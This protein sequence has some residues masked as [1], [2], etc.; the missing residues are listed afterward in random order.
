MALTHIDCNIFRGPGA[1]SDGSSYVVMN[2]RRM[3]G[4][5][6]VAV[7]IA[8]KESISS[9]V[10]CKL[11]LE[12]FTAGVLD[13]YDSQSEEGRFDRRGDSAGRQSISLE[14]LEAAFK[15]ANTSVYQFAHK[16]AA[17]GRMASTLMGVVLEDKVIAAGK[18]GPGNVFLFRNRELMAFF[19]PNQ[20]LPNEIAHETYIGAHS[21]VSVELASIP[22]QQSDQIFILP[23]NV[24]KDEQSEMQKLLLERDDVENKAA[25]ICKHI[26]PDV[27][28]IPF[29]ACASLGPETIYLEQAV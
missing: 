21:F 6:V 29:C 14:V 22:A 11:G 4:N 1:S 15:K 9:Q 10:A 27:Y 7:S 20:N 3:P 5:L 25:Y 13:F 28:K 23:F 12:H 18:V 2:P 16:L 19:E 17:G 26:F 24:S 8:A